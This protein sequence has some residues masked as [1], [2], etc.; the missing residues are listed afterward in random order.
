MNKTISI[1]ISGL[2]F[3]IEEH[4][5]E[6][7]KKYL[8]SIKRYF[9][10]EE[11]GNEIIA[12]IEARIAELFQE[13]LNDEK[14][15]ILEND[16]A[17]I[18]ENLGQPQEMLEEDELEGDIED[19]KPKSNQNQWNNSKRTYS[20]QKKIF[21]D[22]D[23]KLI[24][25]VCSGLAHYFGIDSI[26][27]RII[28]ILI[29][30]L[31]PGTGVVVY[32][33]LWA[34][35]PEALT[36]ADKLRMKGKPVNVSNIEDSIK[37][38]F[39]NIGDDLS[40][41][42]NDPDNKRKI[43]KGTDTLSGVIQAMVGFIGTIFKIVLKIVAVSLIVASIAAIII[44]SIAFFS[45]F[46][47]F[48]FVFHDLVSVVFP[49]AWHGTLLLI[50]LLL[51]V[52]IPLVIIL[53]R[54][55]QL[56]LKQGS[57]G[58]PIMVT[59]F[60]VWIVSVVG[61]FAQ[62]MFFVV[63]VKSEANVEREIDLNNPN[64]NRYYI[65]TKRVPVSSGKTRHYGFQHWSDDQFYFENDRF[66][67]QDVAFKIEKSYDNDFHL[68]QRT[69]SQGADYNGAI[70]YAQ[71]VEYLIEQNDSTLFLNPYLSIFD[72]PYRFQD[73][74]LILQVPAEK[75]IMFINYTYGINNYVG[76]YTNFYYEYPNKVFKMKND[77]LEY[78]AGVSKS[79]AENGMLNY[80]YSGFDEIKIESEEPIRAQIIEGN[81]YRVL[82]SEELSNK[83]RLE[84][85]ANH[86]EFT[87]EIDETRNDM[88]DVPV[89][90][91]IEVP[92]LREFTCDGVGTYIIN[93]EKSS[94]IIDLNFLGA[95][96]GSFK[97]HIDNLDITVAGVS[98]LNLSGSVQDLNCDIAGSSKISAFDMLV[99]NID[100]DLA[101]VCKAEF[102]VTN[103]LSIDA[104]GSSLVKYK[105]NPNIHKNIAGVAIVEKVD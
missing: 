3:N 31:L 62:A 9:K 60:V 40:D 65:E 74:T 64:T 86:N 23:E 26:W 66:Y 70:A 57:I 54:A 63:D 4:A 101:G 59:A 94:G 18:I 99:E 38:G 76:D 8:D 87:I 83:K 89:H 73:V 104:G 21:R 77:G 98:N 92:S 2:F 46:S 13:K 84:F 78:L 35:V 50:T 79:V 10:N 28:F 68:I 48:G 88:L 100:A 102:Y 55:F 16:V 90:I 33:I 82:I 41:F 36:T 6:I 15:V 7:L 91:I 58:K 47:I 85:R 32:G 93:T 20:N 61:L 103:H 11:S 67:F 29:T 17:E 39:Q 25:G 27:I 37:R 69:K 95:T 24:G 51:V 71:S 43:K 52:A 49:S 14:S 12:D 22:V 96:D 45:S 30:F 34:I 75:E 72:A 44:L 19:E 5:F 1:N 42:V 56:L 53:I 105:G 97:G 80:S 81:E